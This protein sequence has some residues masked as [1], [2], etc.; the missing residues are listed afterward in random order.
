[1]KSRF[2]DGRAAASDVLEFVRDLTYDLGDVLGQRWRGELDDAFLEAKGFERHFRGLLAPL[3][4]YAVSRA[5]AIVHLYF[6]PLGR[7]P[8]SLEDLADRSVRVS[9]RHFLGA[10]DLRSSII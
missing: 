9:L 1:M 10:G 5:G 3:D 6:L 4:R 7:V 8:E 2:P